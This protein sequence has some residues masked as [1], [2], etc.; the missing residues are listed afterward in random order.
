MMGP[1]SRRCSSG[2]MR[3]RGPKPRV[4]SPRVGPCQTSAM[5][6][7]RKRREGAA[8]RQAR[9]GTEMIADG[10]SDK[11]QR[12]NRGGRRD[13]KDEAYN[14]GRR[15]APPRKRTSTRGK[16]AENRARAV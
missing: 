9:G 15:L 10:S 12:K 6:P 4:S 14:H 13:G 8:R 5:E 16:G 1:M 11:R 3:A 7:P 2:A